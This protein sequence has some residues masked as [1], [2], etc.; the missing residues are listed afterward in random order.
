MALGGG[1]GRR[2]LGGLLRHAGA[3]AAVCDYVPT[4]W[5]EG[6]RTVVRRVRVDPGEVRADPRSRR[7]RTIRPDQL[8]LALDG[9][10]TDI[11][12]YS[13]ICTNLD[14]SAEMLEYW[15]RER[16]WIEERHKDAKLGYGLIHLPSGK[17]RV[18]QAW[19]WSPYLATNPS[20]FTQ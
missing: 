13:F 11:D 14:G 6:T 15:F 4:G 3:Q 18:N 9:E 16:A 17:F 12:A 1:G 5:P 8:A 20:S 19:M 10:A 2:C 7:R